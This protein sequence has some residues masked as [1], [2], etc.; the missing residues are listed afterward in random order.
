MA[1]PKS[2]KNA[3]SEVVAREYTIHLSRRVHGVQ[4]KRR[5]PKAV[6]VVRDFAHK[7][8]GTSDV[9]LDPDLNKALWSKGIKGI[10]KR[11]RVRISRKRNNEEGATEKLFS[12][13]QFV[14]VDSFKGLDT[15]VV[16][17]E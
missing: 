12:Y 17:D 6:K 16:D 11:I 15:A 3:I 5:A 2:T 8:M 7:E 9:R 13:V 4:F 14:H 1:A 10:P